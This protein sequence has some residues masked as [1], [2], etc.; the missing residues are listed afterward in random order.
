MTKRELI[1][2]LTREPIVVEQ[3]AKL[4]QYRISLH[5][6]PERHASVWLGLARVAGT[7]LVEDYASVYAR[8]NGRVVRLTHRETETVMSRLRNVLAR[9]GVPT[10]TVLPS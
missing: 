1:A 4:A 9:G 8:I 7:L 10:N 3:V 6:A 2:R 5:D